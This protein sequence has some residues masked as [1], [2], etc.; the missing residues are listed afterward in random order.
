MK[1]NRGTTNLNTVRKSHAHFGRAK[2]ERAATAAGA[3]S[4]PRPYRDRAT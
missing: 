1:G 3:A 4:L 2:T